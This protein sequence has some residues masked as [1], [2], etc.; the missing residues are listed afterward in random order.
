MLPAPVTSRFQALRSGLINLFKYEQQEFWFE[1]GRLLVRGNN[2]TGK[3]RVLALQLP[4]LLDGRIEARYV[5]PDRDPARRIDWHLLMDQYRERTGYTWIEFGRRDEAGV[6]HYVTLGIGLRAVHG[7]DS[8]RWFF[9][10]EERVGAGFQLVENSHPLSKDRLTEVLGAGCLYPSPR[11]YRAE[12]DRRLFSLGRERYESL[13]ELLIQLRSPQLNKKLEAQPIFD[14][15]SDALPPL[16]ENVVQDVADAF[17]RLDELRAEFHALSDLSKSLTAFRASYQTYL[18]AA[19]HR[20]AGDV[21]A[22]HSKY[23]DAS[24]KVTAIQRDIGEAAEREAR[25]EGG[26][27][28][29]SDAFARTEIH[30]Q[31]LKD[32][33]DADKARL[34]DDAERAAS[35]AQ[36]RYS[37]ARQHAE[38][39]EDKLAKAV[40]DVASQQ[41]EHDARQNDRDAVWRNAAEQSQSAGFDAE[42]QSLMPWPQDS[43]AFGRLKLEY[44]QLA[45]GHMHRLDQVDQLLKLVDDAHAFLRK[46]QANEDR[47]ADVVNSHRAD[48]DRHHLAAE[49]SLKNLA[50]EYTEWHQRLRW[51]KLPVFSELSQSMDDWLETADSTHRILAS[52]VTK[53]GEAEA[54]SRSQARTQCNHALDQLM[55]EKERLELL[56]TELAHEAPPPP[57]PAFRDAASRLSRRGAPLWKICE[58]HPSLSDTQRAGLEAALE[59]SGILDAWITPEGTLV[60]ELPCDSFLLGQ[61]PTSSASTLAT[62]LVPD[63]PA[64]GDITP[65]ILTHVLNG[66]GAGEQHSSHWVTLDGRWQLG[67]VYGRSSKQ[68]SQYLGATSRELARV[69]RLAEVEEQLNDLQ[70]QE[71]ALIQEQRALDAREQEAGEESKSAPGDED[72]FGSLTLRTDARVKQTNADNAHALAV[73]KTQKARQQL[74]EAE[75]KL[76]RDTVN[77]GYEKHLHRLCELRS[78]WTTYDRVITEAWGCLQAWI[79]TSQHLTAAQGRERVSMEEHELRLGELES[80]RV[81]ELQAKQA[82]QTLLKNSGASVIDYQTQLRDAEDSKSAAR[83]HLKG[84]EETLNQ[85]KIQHATHKAQLDPAKKNVDEAEGLRDRAIATLRVPALHGLFPEAHESLVDVEIDAWAATRAV[86]IARRIDKELPQMNVSDEAWTRRLNQLDEHINILRTSIGGTCDVIDQTISQGLKVVECRYHGVM[87]KPAGCLAAV[88]NECEVRERLLG[89]REREIIDH[90]LVA[91]VSMRLRA[92]IEGAAIRTEQM[93]EEMTRCATTLGLTMKLVW[94]PKTEDLPQG[95]PAVRKLLLGDHAIWTPLERQTVG[96]CLH[97]LIQDQRIANPKATAAEQLQ[98]ALD[99]RKWHQF[100]AMRRQSD[101]GKWERLTKQK[102]GTGSGGEKALLITIP[103]MAAA[104]SHYQ[105]AAKHAPRFILLDEAFVGLDSPTRAQLMGLLEAFDLDLVMTSEREWGT[106]ATVSGIAIY[107]LVANADAV[108]ATR[109]VWNGATCLPAPVPDTP[110]LR[111]LAS[112]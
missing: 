6:E 66:I 55:H 86:A 19:I 37:T 85:A 7:G 31:T 8:N 81:V 53:A 91:E 45:K 104:S 112:A 92:L 106:H 30:L 77:L 36:G 93:N 17:K 57:I 87:H 50:E 23:E 16:A 75:I 48:A 78:A 26:L 71:Q 89:E 105:T 60:G 98:L 109:W 101:K 88:D 39:A 35:Q 70:R 52:I 22:T 41:K 40:A 64:D 90:H 44:Q 58:F 63:L 76:N 100:Y 9:V 99:Y 4:F 103:K 34:L 69:R 21:R 96:D 111:S 2:G 59:A 24:R 27:T 13:I 61:Q 3:S 5:E 67:P 12:I 79:S 94:D 33:E 28:E 65:E 62:W 73:E 102:Y 80:A 38:A 68:A 47:A 74:D 10:T 95:L 43:A 46:E 51:L 97:Q 107:Q 82:H 1:K 14:A 25:A 84:A 108:A 32:S 83:S 56:R 11:E 18:Q 72:I 15:L 29:A 42:H 110:E 49:V 54:A 20:L